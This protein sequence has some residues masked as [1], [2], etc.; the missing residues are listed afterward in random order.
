[1]ASFQSRVIGAM[2]LNVATYEEVEHDASATMQAGAVV[3]LASISGALGW[4]FYNGLSGVVTG[5]IMSLIG[6]VI[7]AT[8]VW[9]VGTKLLPGPKTEADIGQL[10]R[11]VG[12]AQAPGLL[13][14]VTVIPVLG[15]FIM[16]GIWIWSLVAWVIAVRQALDY[17]DTLRAVL[18]CA[19][20]WAVMFFVIM[21]GGLMLGL[22]AAAT[23]AMT[24]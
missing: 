5:A 4:I 10:M 6:W 23:G 17:D 18:V 9:L 13:G 3:L 16:V 12:F 8:V 11:T 14:F 15:W 22:G 20:A 24:S 21:V 1:M 2:T 19:I 7:G